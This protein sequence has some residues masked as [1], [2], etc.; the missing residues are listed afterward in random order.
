LA[1]VRLQFGDNKEVVVGVVLE[2]NGA[3]K[4]SFRLE[5]ILPLVGYIYFESAM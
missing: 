3:Q 4:D 2:C 5:L 1:V